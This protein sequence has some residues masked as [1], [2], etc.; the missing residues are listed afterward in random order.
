ML[1]GWKPEP[2]KEAKEKPKKE[3]K[4]GK[5][6]K[7]KSKAKV[8][9]SDDE[10]DDDDD[11]E[12]QEAASPSRKRKHTPDNDDE[13]DADQKVEES[14]E[15]SDV[16]DI[17]P[18]KRKKGSK[19]EPSSPKKAKPKNPP[20]KPA[21]DEDPLDSEI[22]KLQSQLTKCGVRKMWHNEL[23]DYPDARGKIRHLKQ[24]LTDIG[25]D[26]RFSEAK[27]REI[28]ETR[29]L[30]ADVEAAKE[31]N[32]LWGAEGEGRASRNKGRTKKIVD[33]ASEGEDEQ[34]DEEDEE[35]VVAAKKRA[36]ADLAFLGDSDSDSD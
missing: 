23:K 6:K 30:L 26:G 35:V 10:N 27:A 21:G 3:I 4:N 24:M 9:D 31:M 28:K 8:Q 36:R 25:M 34:D 17:V 14:D 19:K 1:E 29:E 5:P 2:K 7:S 33:S 13:E 32:A 22:K 15:Y 12:E 18:T 20:K 16:I 11:E